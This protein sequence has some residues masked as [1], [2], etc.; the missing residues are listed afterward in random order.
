MCD[1]VLPIA[2]FLIYCVVLRGGGEVPHQA[3]NLGIAGSIPA[4]ATTMQKT[5]K[6]AYVVFC[7]LGGIFD[8]KKTWSHIVFC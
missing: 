1:F 2:F 4:P 8:L 3:H 7:F 6:T 5:K